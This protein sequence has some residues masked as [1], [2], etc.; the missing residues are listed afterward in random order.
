M[1]RQFTNCRTRQ[2][3]TGPNKT[4][5]EYMDFLEQRRLIGEIISYGYEMVK[6]RLAGNWKTTYKPDFYVLRTDGQLEVHEVKGF[7]EDD[8]AVKLKVAANRFPFLIFKLVRKKTK[9][10]GGGWNIEII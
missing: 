1:R 5:S 3:K 10:E 2:P 8:A 4:E 6:F 7:M 9:K